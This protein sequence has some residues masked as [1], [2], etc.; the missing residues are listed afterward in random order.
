MQ[1]TGSGG[2]YKR[3]KTEAHTL[4]CGSRA[5]DEDGSG[6]HRRG[7]GTL[8]GEVC[9]RDVARAAPVAAGSSRSS[10]QAQR[11]VISRPGRCTHRET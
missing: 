8:S 7:E 4:Y 10:A 11:A 3:A 5:G 2:E 6:E 9:G 1:I